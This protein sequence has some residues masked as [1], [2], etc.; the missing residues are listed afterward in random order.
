[1][2]PSRFPFLLASSLSSGSDLDT[3]YCT[4]SMR[5]RSTEAMFA[6]A[7][8]SPFPNS[9][10]TLFLL[11]TLHAQ[12]LTVF[13]VVE[14][15]GGDYALFLRQYFGLNESSVHPRLAADVFLDGGRKLLRSQQQGLLSVLRQFGRP[16]TIG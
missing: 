13:L 10:S 9:F 14:T 11:T 2:W 16:A 3:D 6:I 15:S 4:C 8:G 12:P 1:M 5:S 7:S